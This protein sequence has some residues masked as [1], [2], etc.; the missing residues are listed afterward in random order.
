MSLARVIGA[1]LLVCALVF[2]VMGF[3]HAQSGVVD[4]LRKLFSGDFRDGATWLIVGAVIAGVL[5]VIA[6]TRPHRRFVGEE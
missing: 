2:L 5:G 6:M 4:E 3:Q 1:V